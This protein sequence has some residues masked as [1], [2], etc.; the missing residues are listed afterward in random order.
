[1]T[2]LLLFF[3]HMFVSRH[4][5]QLPVLIPERCS[6][7]FLPVAFY[8]R[9]PLKRLRLFRHSWPWHS[10][11]LPALPP[12]HF[13]H[14]VSWPAGRT[15]TKPTTLF[16]YRVPILLTNIT[17]LPFHAVLN[18][19]LT[20]RY[21]WYS[22]GAD[23]YRLL[24][25]ITD[26]DLRLLY[27]RADDSCLRLPSFG[28]THSMPDLFTSMPVLT[29][30]LFPY[31]GNLTLLCLRWR[32]RCRWLVCYLV[33]LIPLFDPL[34]PV[35]RRTVIGDIAFFVT[36]PTCFNSP[37]L[38]T[39]TLLLHAGTHSAQDVDDRR[40]AYSVD[41]FHIVHGHH[42]VVCPRRRCGM[43]SRPDDDTSLIVPYKPCCLNIHCSWYG[44][45]WCC[46][47]TRWNDCWPTVLRTWHTM[48]TAVVMKPS[49]AC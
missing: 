20:C 38:Y 8:C 47:M 34:L 14:P 28:V 25:P 49:V 37:R 19:V 26:T 48:P 43:P 45:W 6:W 39:A 18:T 30:R 3:L 1:M 33:L 12:A 10:P 36:L 31:L 24:I 29:C 7:R 5:C 22:F 23:V 32:C 16:S 41:C 15:E 4:F 13:V 21:C 11:P 35:R 40:L 27:C 42:S 17:F 2:P 46:P 9:P 44:R